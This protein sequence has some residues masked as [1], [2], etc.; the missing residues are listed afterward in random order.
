MSGERLRS[1]VSESV[2]GAIVIHLRPP[3]ANVEND[4]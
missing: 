3:V 4:E 1:Q 2:A